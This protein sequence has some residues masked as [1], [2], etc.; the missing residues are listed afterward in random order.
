M[1]SVDVVWDGLKS[2]SQYIFPSLKFRIS[3]YGIVFANEEAF[4]SVAI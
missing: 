3:G 2:F 1:H 4:V